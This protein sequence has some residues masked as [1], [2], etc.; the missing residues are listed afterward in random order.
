MELFNTALV[1]EMELIM[2]FQTLCIKSE[3]QSHMKQQISLPKQV[4]ISSLMSQLYCHTLPIT[5]KD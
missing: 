2:E 5:Q 4:N 3:L 1:L